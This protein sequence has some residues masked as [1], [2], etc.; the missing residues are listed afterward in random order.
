MHVLLCI[1]VYQ[2]HIIQEDKYVIKAFEYRIHYSLKYLTR[3]TYAKS[4]PD[5]SKRQERLEIS[6]ILLGYQ[7]LMIASY[8]IV[9]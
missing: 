2:E 7:N 3:I 1:L 8:K 6:H 5:D 4:H 9:F